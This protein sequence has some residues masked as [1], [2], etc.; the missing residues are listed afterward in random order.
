MAFADL[1][2]DFVFRRIFATHP[3][4]LRGLLNDLLDRRDEEA[5]V[6]IEY[7][8]SEQLPLVVGAKLSILD[9]RCKD[10]AGT[11]FVVEM[12]LIHVAGFINRVV[13]NACKAYVGQ[14]KAGERYSTLADVVAISICDFELWPDAGQKERKLPL[15]PM[16]SRWNMQEHTS[17]SPGLLQVQYA[18]LELPKLPERKPETGAAYW[19]WL[20]VH[21][22]ELTEVPPDL[23][24][25]PYREALEL[26]NK[27]TFSP[28]EL[29]AYQKVMDEIQQAREYGE[30]KWAEGEAAGFA[31]G[32]TAGQV[33][34]ILA[35]L[36]A[37]GIAVSSET[38]AR[39]EACK[40]AAT[41]DRWITR[42][43]TAGSAEEVIA[44]PSQ[45]A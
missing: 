16:L 18:F 2:N 12:Q 38:R 28:A 42:A 6:S 17:G 40:D 31:K 13:Y 39:I 4:I 21:A 27:T 26:A 41:L 45:R 37:R 5:I 15:V 7:L 10:R 19:A 25:G 44:A 3:D 32:E 33:R 22:P 29:E 30:A 24:P 8:P 11:T 20:F 9:V 14:L 1:K 34:A 36:A 43:A 23:P 35:L